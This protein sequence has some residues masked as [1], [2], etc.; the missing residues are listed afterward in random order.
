VAVCATHPEVEAIGA[1]AR[2]GLFICAA[3]QN[4]LDEQS[5]CTTCAARDD[6]DWLGKHYAK[7]EG[8]RSGMAWTMLV[9]GLGLTTIVTTLL[10]DP[11]MDGFGP[12]GAALLLYAGGCLFFF[13]GHPKARWAVA[14]TG[15]VTG[16]L[17]AL[18]A[19]SWLVG[20]LLGLALVV[21]GVLGATDLRSRLFFRVPVDRSS[22]RKHFE[23]YGNNPL[24]ITAS[25]LALVSLF[26][27]GL[28]LISLGLGVYSLTRVD[29]KA[30]PPVGST[31]VA[32]GAII[33][34]LVTTALYAVGISSAQ[35]R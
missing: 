23:R 31:S 17:F 28:G 2:C 10:F 11:A 6:V 13:S 3:D 22:L 30:T 32:V 14:I 33:F 15:A 12:F 26:V 20:A 29:L 7:L 16:G 21:F 1:C 9:A 34:S 19:S 8:K 35:F 18:S 25:R 27:P 4:V 5:Y 24:A